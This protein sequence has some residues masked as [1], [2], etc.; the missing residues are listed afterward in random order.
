MAISPDGTKLVTIGMEHNNTT[1][2]ATS[3][4]ASQHDSQPGTRMIVYDPRSKDVISLVFLSQCT[5]IRRST[6][7][8]RDV[9]FENE[10]TSV[11]ISQ[12]SQF[13][14]LNHAPHVRCLFPL[15]T[16]L[17]VYLPVRRNFG[18]GI[19]LMIDWLR[20]SSDRNKGIT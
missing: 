1:R 5:A 8:C 12:D 11:N 15:S 10:L 4:Q 16:S 14:V 3:S 18:Y 9:D 2:P 6:K 7:I 19:F 17:Y 20:S 13:A